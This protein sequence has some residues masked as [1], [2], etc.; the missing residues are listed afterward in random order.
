MQV[1]AGI[2]SLWYRQW[3]SNKIGSKSWTC[4]QHACLTQH[5]SSSELNLHFLPLLL[6][7]LPAMPKTVRAHEILHVS[8]NTPQIP[9]QLSQGQLSSYG[10]Q[11]MSRSQVC[12]FW[13]ERVKINA[14]ATPP[15]LVLATLMK[16][17]PHEME[18]Q[19]SMD[20]RHQMENFSQ[21]VPD[22]VI[23]KSALSC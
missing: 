8:L 19:G 12:R 1:A 11:T 14:S 4:N 2:P 16:W 22:F 15:F 17:V 13:V 18:E 3:E 5:P 10:P 7:Q 21:P 6:I 23:V 20:P 9:L